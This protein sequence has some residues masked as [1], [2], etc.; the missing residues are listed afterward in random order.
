MFCQF[1]PGVGYKSVAYIKKSVYITSSGSV[2]RTVSSMFDTEKKMYNLVFLPSRHTTSFQRLWEI[3]TTSVMS[4]RRLADVETTLCVYWVEVHNSVRQYARQQMWW[5]LYIF[6]KSFFV[7]QKRSFPSSPCTLF[8]A[9]F[10]LQPP[11]MFLTHL[12]KSIICSFTK[13]CYKIVIKRNSSAKKF[14]EVTKGIE[15][16]QQNAID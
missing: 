7:L 8:F 3:F 12:Y 9:I 2:S 14:L 4:Y 5:I 11:V 16:F 10:L 6:I 15:R 13:R 1:Q